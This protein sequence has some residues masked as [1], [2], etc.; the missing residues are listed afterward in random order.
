MELRT[1]HMMGRAADVTYLG[2]SQ[3]FVKENS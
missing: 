1:W 2:V 3:L